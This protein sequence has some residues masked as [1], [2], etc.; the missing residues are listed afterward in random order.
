MNHKWYK[1]KEIGLVVWSWECGN[2]GLTGWNCN[3]YSDIQPTHVSYK[4]NPNSIHFPL[5]FINHEFKF[6]KILQ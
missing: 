3:G 6:K 1:V 4:N 2:C 5:C